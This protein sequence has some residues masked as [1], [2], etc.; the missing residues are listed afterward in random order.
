MKVAAV[1]V[2]FQPDLIELKSLINIISD[3]L[4]QI[5]IFD[6]A[7][8]SQ[9]DIKQ[10][11]LKNNKISFECSEINK[12]I[13]F[14]QNRG[15]EKLDHSITHFVLLD[16]DT[17][18]PTG[19]ITQ[20]LMDFTRFKKHNSMLCAVSA[21]MVNPDMPTHKN[22]SFMQSWFPVKQLIKLLSNK[23]KCFEEFPISSGLLIDK[24][25]FNT[26]GPFNEKLF[27][28]LVDTEWF[29]RAKSMGCVFKNSKKSLLKHAPGVIE[30]GLRFSSP[31]RAYYQFRNSMILLCDIR[32]R[33][34][35]HIALLKYLY[36]HLRAIFYFSHPLQ[37][38][39]YSIS[40]I[41]CGLFYLVSYIS[42]LFFN[43]CYRQM[44]K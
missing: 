35:C 43:L 37:R 26:V 14:G 12:G 10:I 23:I 28:D 39:Y 31:K 22:Q 1:I 30:L 19:A 38:I 40:G 7:S 16:Q 21:T 8:A 24:S 36:H 25:F 34:Y 41:L 20:L 15:V 2:T 17:I 4:H 9:K 29:L 13:A 3:E 32:T 42:Y 6:N 11:A 44:R 27:I 33:S 18:V 5:I